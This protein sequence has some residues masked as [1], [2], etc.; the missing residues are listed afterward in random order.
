LE[1]ILKLSLRTVCLIDEALSLVKSKTSN[2]GLWSSSASLSDVG[3]KE[4]WCN[5][6]HAYY[7]YSVYFLKQLSSKYIRQFFF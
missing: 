2:L 7:Y 5:L 6:R 3:L 1:A 4:F